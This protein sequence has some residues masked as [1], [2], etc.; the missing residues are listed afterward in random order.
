MADAVREFLI[1]TLLRDEAEAGIDRLLAKA[2]A[3][4]EKAFTITI[5][6]STADVEKQINYLHKAVV[7]FP[8]Q[9]SDKNIKDQADGARK[10][11]DQI[12]NVSKQSNKA[13]QSIGNFFKNLDMGRLILGAAGA[14]LALYAGQLVNTYENFK[15]N[16]DLIKDQMRS[17]STDLMAFINQGGQASG[18][19]SEAGRA[20]LLNYMSM[21]GYGSESRMKEI[22][23]NAEKIM[24][25]TFGKGLQQFGIKNELDL[26]KTLSQPVSE[27][28]DLG[29]ALK[30]KMPELFKYSTFQGEVVN[31][32]QE[33]NFHYQS[34]PVIEAEARRRLMEKA[35]KT[36]GAEVTPDTDTYRRAMDD[37]GAATENLRQK[38]GQTLEPAITVIANFVT[39][40]LKM[41]EANPEVATLAGTILVLGT[42]LS[43]LAAI[44]PLV[45]AGIGILTGA[46]LT[47]PFVLAATAIALVV[48]GLSALES[49]FHVFSQAWEKFSKSAIGKDLINSVIS[50]TD[51]VEL[52]LGP[53]G[54][55]LG[56]LGV[57]GKGSFFENL[58]AGGEALSNLIG[59]IFDKIDAIYR[60]AKGGDI[61][62]AFKG[63]LEMSLKVSPI[64]VVSGIIDALLPLTNVQK[65]SLIILQDVKTI[66]KQLSQWIYS[67]IDPI[68]QLYNVVKDK[69]AGFLEYI[70]HGI[71]KLLEKLGLSAATENKPDQWGRTG[72]KFGDYINENAPKAI[73]DLSRNARMGDL[74]AQ[75]EIRK[76]S[77]EYVKK[78]FTDATPEDLASGGKYSQNVNDVY[79]LLNSFGTNEYDK[80]RMALNE[81]YNMPSGAGAG[82]AEKSLTPSVPFNPATKNPEN[83][84]EN[85]Q[86]TNKI[87]A[88]PI[89][90][91]TKP[92]EDIKSSADVEGGLQVYARSLADAALWLKGKVTGSGEPTPSGESTPNTETPAQAPSAPTSFEPDKIYQ[93]KDDATVVITGE[94]ANR[95]GGLKPADY[96]QKNALGGEVTK[97]G[98]GWI[99]IGEPIVPAEVARSSTLIDRLREI[100]L[101]RSSPDAGG[102]GAGDYSSGLHIDKVEINLQGQQD[103]QSIARE[104]RSALD[105]ELGSFEFGQ[106]VEFAVHRANRAYRG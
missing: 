67:I 69:V 37:M 30:S 73:E 90:I 41:A 71:E 68:I 50:L 10:L 3:L 27:T 88:G 102:S 84:L 42:S 8:K 79:D 64:S 89:V 19:T 82:Q 32:G 24:H 99:D 44:L 56:V 36:I 6:T 58:V 105:R 47:N 91:Q 72:Q 70:W 49:R 74:V 4:A 97:S 34:Q 75:K 77:E 43:I 53:L 95:Y 65:E 31:V 35:L 40:I 94:E 54:L 83:P 86:F 80:N 96:I 33:K 52:L 59:G 87:D 46:L 26:V 7:E 38:I 25:S 20:G 62:G 100:A 13:S 11:V 61:L 85:P 101:G 15:L 18:T 14:G 5:K 66:W 98:I 103:A 81:K 60:M 57:F 12:D 106:K 28:S 48:I 16:I 76:D 17:A 23:T 29:R 104:V 39:T 21:T 78:L 9:T 51:H 55:L 2:R 63:G 45:S 93:K 92:A 22:A 1:R